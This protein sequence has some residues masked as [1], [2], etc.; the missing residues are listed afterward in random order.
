MFKEKKEGILLTSQLR[1]CAVHI[2]SHIYYNKLS[3]V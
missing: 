3:A 1:R 2:C